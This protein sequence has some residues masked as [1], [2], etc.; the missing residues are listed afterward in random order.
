MNTR[1]LQ[2]DRIEDF[3][4]ALES[5][6]SCSGRQSCMY[7]T[8]ARTDPPPPPPTHT[9]HTRV[10]TS[11]QPPYPL[12]CFRPFSAR[13]K[14]AADGPTNAN[15]APPKAQQGYTSSGW[16]LRHRSQITTIF[17]AA[18]PI[19]II[20]MQYTLQKPPP[21]PPKHT[22]THLLQETTSQPPKNNKQKRKI[23]TRTKK[24]HTVN[25]EFWPQEA[26]MVRNDRF[27]VAL[28][29]HTTR[30]ACLGRRHDACDTKHK[31]QEKESLTLEIKNWQ[32][33]YIWMTCCSERERPF[34]GLISQLTSKLI[35]ATP[36]KRSSIS[37]RESLRLSQHETK[38]NRKPSIRHA[39]KKKKEKKKRKKPQFDGFKRGASWLSY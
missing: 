3:T 11:L 39:R 24:R 15:E 25:K 31:I 8:C 38:A 28:Y 34:R 12:P 27:L 6:T 18:L 14:H 17:Q 26:W 13:C 22:H 20:N 9:S 4:H 21:P 10:P 30:A 36:E 5:Q 1:G 16:R 19:S 23:T 29:R 37:K 35:N 32:S 7:R 33:Q 2:P